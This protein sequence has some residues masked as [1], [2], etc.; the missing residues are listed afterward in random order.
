MKRPSLVGPFLRLN[1]RVWDSIPP[2]VVDSR[3]VRLC[4]HFAHAL[5]RRWGHRRQFFGTYFLRN[6]PQ[7]ELIRRLSYQAEH[8]SRLNIAV[9]G[10]SNGAEVYS[11][12]ATLRMARPELSVALHAVD[13]S[14]EVLDLAKMGSYSLSRPELVD[15]PIFNRMSASEVQQMFDRDGDTLKVKAWLREGIS[16]HLGDVRDPAVLETVGHQDIVVAN[17][18]LC[19]MRP[20]DA[21]A[22]LRGIARLVASGGYLIVSGIDLDVRAK[23]AMGDRWK[24]VAELLE[25]IH[26]ADSLRKHWPKDYWGLEPLDKNRK[27]WIMRYAAAFQLGDRPPHNR[28][29]DI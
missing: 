27:D 2:S 13:I 4:G 7:L 24:P 3:P 9:L 17:N 5:V 10:C 6:R 21:E 11:V 18:F 15:E 28:R 1:R 14:Q 22:C 29:T 8:E 23:I 12:L 20:P 19:H 25:D 26:T 16:W